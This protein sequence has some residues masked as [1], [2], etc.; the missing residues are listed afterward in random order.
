MN[1]KI[2][3]L[4]KFERY[5]PPSPSKVKWSKNGYLAII[6]EWGMKNSADQGGWSP[7][8][9]EFFISYVRKLNSLIALLSIQNSFK[10]LKEKMSSLFFCSPK[11][12]QPRPQVS[13]AQQFTNLHRL[14][15]WHHFDIIGPIICIG[16][17]LWGHWFNMT[18]FFL[19]L[20]NGSCLGWIVH[21]V[22]TNQKWGNILNQ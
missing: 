11:I 6:I 2:N 9:A 13:R 14:H 1:Y 15:V 16:L 3:I 12:T 17:H 10:V 19:I 22:L 18:K 7:R 20:V 21:V 4:N 5:W 8:S